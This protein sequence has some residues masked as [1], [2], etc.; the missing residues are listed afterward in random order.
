MEHMGTSKTGPL[1]EVSMIMFTMHNWSR[2]V[3]PPVGEVVHL[4]AVHTSQNKHET[5]HGDGG[6]SELPGNKRVSGLEVTRN[7]GPHVV[8]NRSRPQKPD[9][10]LYAKT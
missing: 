2:Y 5:S 1:A 7:N 3:R 8:E 6:L 9:T 10:R 4:A